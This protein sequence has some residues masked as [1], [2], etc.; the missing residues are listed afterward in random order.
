[1]LTLGCISN[2]KTGTPTAPPTDPHPPLN[3]LTPPLPP[4]KGYLP[5]SS[6]LG[7]VIYKVHSSDAH[8][9]VTN[10]PRAAAADAPVIEAEVDAEALAADMDGTA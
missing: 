4:P 10:S 7:R 2:V 9:P 6:I 3:P 8:G 1:V 5:M